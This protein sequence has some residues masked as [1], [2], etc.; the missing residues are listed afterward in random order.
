MLVVC[1]SRLLQAKENVLH[2]LDGLPALGASADIDAEAAMEDLRTRLAEVEMT[3]ERRARERWSK[4]RR[5]VHN[6]TNLDNALFAFVKAGY[7]QN[8]AV[9]EEESFAPPSPG[10]GPVG[11]RKALE[12]VSPPLR[13]PLGIRDDSDM[14]SSSV[15]DLDEALFMLGTPPTDDDDDV[16][17]PRTLTAVLRKDVSSEALRRVRGFESSIGSLDLSGGCE[18]LSGSGSGS[19]SDGDHDD[20]SWRRKNGA[21]PQ[22]GSGL[23]R[24]ASHAIMVDRPAAAGLAGGGSSPVAAVTGDSDYISDSVIDRSM[25]VEQPRSLLT[26]SLTRSLERLA[27]LG[28]RDGR[29]LAADAASSAAKAAAASASA[30]SKGGEGSEK[31]VW[32]R[33]SWGG[34]VKVVKVRPPATLEAV[35]LKAAKKFRLADPS[36]VG[37]VFAPHPQTGALEAIA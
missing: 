29:K 21:S 27:S 20:Y 17:G 10:R 23:R 7:S 25:P 4:L 34:T 15:D 11:L 33:C 19:G 28:S 3:A 31:P 37:G 30:A 14:R 26:A 9:D 2:L 13:M 24:T 6:A 1:H 16:G 5:S 35:Q 22:A 18:E 32:T 8:A 12:Y 36:V